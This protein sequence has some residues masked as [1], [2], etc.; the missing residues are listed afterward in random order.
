MVIYADSVQGVIRDV[1]TTPPSV[2]DVNTVAAIFGS[3]LAL[4]ILIAIVVAIPVIAVTVRRDKS[5]QESTRYYV[6]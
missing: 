6:Q 1:M 4:V 2:A 3:T 5:K